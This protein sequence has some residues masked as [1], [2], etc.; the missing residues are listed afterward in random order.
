MPAAVLVVDDDAL[1]RT[2]VRRQLEA[3]GFA[4][5]EHD[6]G[7]G[8]KERIAQHRPVACL[9]DL[10]MDVR[11]GIETIQDVLALADRPKVI[12]VSGNPKFLYMADGFGI[13]G[14]LVKPVTPE[15]LRDKLAGLELLAS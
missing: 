9:I 5:I 8:V 7:A 10:V 12:A 4:V 13:D 3:L 15:R 6:K 14:T 1:F 2:I 11:D